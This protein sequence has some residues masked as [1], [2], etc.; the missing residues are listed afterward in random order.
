MAT[1]AE[2][3]DLVAVSTEFRAALD[4]LDI[5]QHRVAKLF[6]ISSR[7]VRRWQHGDRRVPRAVHL[8]INLLVTGAISIDQVEQAAISIP[9]RTNGSAKSG[10][11]APLLVEPTPAP[12][13]ADLDCTTAEKVLA[14]AAN[15]CRWPCGD[16]GH[17]AFHF[18]SSPVTERPYCEHHRALPTWHPRRDRRDVPHRFVS[19]RNDIDGA[20]T[21]LLFDEGVV[22]FLGIFA[23]RAVLLTNKRSGARRFLCRS[24]LGQLA[25]GVAIFLHNLA[26]DFHRL[27]EFGFLTPFAASLLEPHADG[28][29]DIADSAPNK[30]AIAGPECLGEVVRDH[31]RIIEVTGDIKWCALDHCCATK[32]R[33]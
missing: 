2:T 16:P 19:A 6:G 22:E 31:L 13:L 12:A 29:R 17:P 26:G 21:G 10:P 15:A 4:A 33:F 23:K 20:Q 5:A 24:F 14:L 25:Q 18:C 28:V 30:F 8:V 27:L 11:P 7:H 3:S 1:R 9:A 32:P